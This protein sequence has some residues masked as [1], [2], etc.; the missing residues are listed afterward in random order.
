[1]IAQQVWVVVVQAASPTQG[2]PSLYRV[3]RCVWALPRLK[4]S[5]C[6]SW[7]RGSLRVIFSPCAQGAGLW[8]LTASV[9]LARKT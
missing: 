6:T 5:I 7:T 4:A 2:S 8:E 9:R 1:M 3:V